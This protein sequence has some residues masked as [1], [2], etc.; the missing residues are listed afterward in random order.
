MES[1]L[2]PILDPFW[3]HFGSIW[4]PHVPKTLLFTM[5]FDDF[6][7]VVFEAPNEPKRSLGLRKM[8]SSPADQA[9]IAHPSR[10]LFAQVIV[11]LVN[12]KP[13]RN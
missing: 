5:N 13:P 6:R 11:K 12:L 2:G 7:G 8:A 10:H 3:V 1:I 9:Q 4:G